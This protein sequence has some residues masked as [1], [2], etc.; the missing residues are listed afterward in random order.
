[1]CRA[2]VAAAFVVFFAV[3]SAAAYDP[4]TRLTD[5]A[6]VYSHGIGEVRCGSEDE[7]NADPA[8]QFSW[9][10]TNLRLEYSVLPAF[11]CEGALGVGSPGVPLWQQAAGVWTLVREAF[12]LRRWRFQSDEAKVLCQA[13]VYFTDA[14]MQLG[15]TDQEANELYPYALALHMQITTLYPWYRDPACILPPWILPPRPPRATVASAGDVAAPERSTDALPRARQIAH[16]VDARYP[17][18]RVNETSS[19]EVIDSL[20]LFDDAV[21]PHVVPAGNGIYYG[22]CPNAASCPFPGR[23]A[24][25]VTALAPRRVALELAL[26]TFTET[27]ANLVVVCLPTR[28]FILLVFERD[29]LD[30]QRVTDALTAYPPGNTSLQLRTIVDANTLPYLYVPFALSPMP[31]GLDSLLAWPLAAH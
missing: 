5:V 31:N 30:A 27:S 17:G 16:D 19:T 2:A 11:L 3:S 28:R 18:L 10:Y 29:V 12:H 8:S 9:S 24:R 21:D 13:I 22:V 15:A 4:P 26:R 25:P 6:H 23:A 7:W 20:T 14:A 1:V